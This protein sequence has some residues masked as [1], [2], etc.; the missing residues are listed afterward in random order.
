MAARQDLKKAA[1]VAAEA[2]A[3]IVT[4]QAVLNSLPG[5][6]NNKPQQPSKAKK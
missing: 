6:K 5:N 3:V 1:A 4:N 2:Q